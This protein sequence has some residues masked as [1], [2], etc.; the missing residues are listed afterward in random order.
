MN[1]LNNIGERWSLCGTPDI[2]EIE[3]EM[4]LYNLYKLYSIINN[5]ILKI[6]YY[7]QNELVVGTTDN[8]NIFT[9]NI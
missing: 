8:T 9:H 7:K 2:I 1:K 5:I 3:S 6:A 4:K